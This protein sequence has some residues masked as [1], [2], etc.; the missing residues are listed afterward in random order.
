MAKI[1]LTLSPSGDLQEVDTGNVDTKQIKD[2]HSGI[3]HV[4]LIDGTALTVVGTAEEV[5]K[6]V[7]ETRAANGEW[8]ETEW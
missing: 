7:Q 5:I 4:L 2:L 1:T 8:I 3:S 6:K